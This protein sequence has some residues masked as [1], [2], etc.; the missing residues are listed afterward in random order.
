M[1]ISA[2]VDEVL[3]GGADDEEAEGTRAARLR[4]SGDEVEAAASG[5]EEGA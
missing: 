4:R 5:R 1:I 3:T 2:D